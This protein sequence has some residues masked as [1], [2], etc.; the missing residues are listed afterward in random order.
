M[1]NG[2]FRHEALQ[3]NRQSEFGSIVLCRPLSFAALTAV[4]VGAAITLCVFLVF[5]DYTK[6]TH[7]A[8]QLVP[9]QG[10]VKLHAREPS[11]IRERRVVEGQFVLKGDVLFVLT[12]ER[13]SAGDEA[14]DPAVARE[15]EFRRAALQREAAAQSALRSQELR[16][17]E[18]RLAG[19]YS[20]LTQARAE[21]AIQQ[22]RVQLAVDTARRNDDLVVRGFMSEAQAQLRQSEV[23]AERAREVALARTVAAAEAEVAAL[24]QARLDLPLKSDAAQASAERAASALDQE[25]REHSARR[26]FAIRAPHDGYVTAIQV[27][28]GHTATPST[29]LA[30][31][32]PAEGELLAHLY[33][34][35]RAI[36]FIE[37]GRAVKLRYQAFPYQKFGQYGATVQS[38]SKT[39][40]SPQEQAG[41]GFGPGG[42]PLYRIIVKLDSQQVLAYGQPQPL[43]AGTQLDA[44]ILLDTRRLIEWV[45]E[46]LFSL[47][48]KA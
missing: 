44:D 13:V 29:P 1:S 9:A 37:P 10:V 46:P 45:F 26:E 32:V 3:S 22:S 40:L 18:Q 19:A 20:Q 15:I 16:A 39:A 4:A 7:V 14:V 6:K 17:I 30:S 47:T 34:P 2:V 24:K 36:G 11:N 43:Q 38:V 12:A 33:A 31:L 21:Y 41:L 5:A 48:R 23:L 35:S 25:G 8:G 28:V 27:D 42:D